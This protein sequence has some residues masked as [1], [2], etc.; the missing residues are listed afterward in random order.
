MLAIC[1]AATVSGG[2]EAQGFSTGAFTAAE[3]VAGRRDYE[4]HCSVCHG[5]DLKGKGNVPALS[6]AVFLNSWEELKVKELQRYISA[7][8]HLD[9]TGSL[10]G[11]AYVGIVAHVLSANGARAGGTALDQGLEAKIGQAIAR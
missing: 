11:E 1:L 9:A 8:R 5:T 6:G 10:N 3:A 2:A 4:Y 7:G